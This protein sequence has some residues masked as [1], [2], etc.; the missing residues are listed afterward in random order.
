MEAGLARTHGKEQLTD[1]V[2]DLAKHGELL[3]GIGAVGLLQK[4]AE[5]AHAPVLPHRVC[6]W[7]PHQICRGGI[8][9]RSRHPF[10]SPRS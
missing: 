9:L 1:L 6:R 2:H 3:R 5:G 10:I 7:L 8:H 4:L